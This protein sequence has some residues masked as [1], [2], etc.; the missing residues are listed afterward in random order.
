MILEQPSEAEVLSVQSV[1]SVPVVPWV[2][3]A[4]TA[5]AL[6]AQS[7]RLSEFAADRNPVDVGFS[8]AT[9]RAVLDHRA[10]LIGDRTV[11]GAVTQG[12]TG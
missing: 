12:R 4:K 1:P 5:E 9:T 2:V 7:E 6:V 3:S 8:L 10:V 11:S